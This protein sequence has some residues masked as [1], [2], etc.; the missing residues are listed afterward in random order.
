MR[1]TDDEKRA[2][3]ELLSRITVAT[4]RM[5]FLLEDNTTAEAIE[6]A[7]VA[8]QKAFDNRGREEAPVLTLHQDKPS[9]ETET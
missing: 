6:A 3:F 7:M 5:V 4:E 9:E 8:A 2:L 1:W